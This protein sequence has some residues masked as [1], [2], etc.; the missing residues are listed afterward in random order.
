MTAEVLR[1]VAKDLERLTTRLDA[2]DK[3]TRGLELTQAVNNSKWVLVGA[4]VIV[5]LG[6]FGSVAAGV[7]SKI[8]TS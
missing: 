7:F 3:A 8:F 1:V 2:G 6:A 4:V 5:V